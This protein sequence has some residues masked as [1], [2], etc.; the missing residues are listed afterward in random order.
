MGRI[1]CDRCY[2]K[3]MEILR[4]VVIPLRGGYTSLFAEIQ[5]PNCG[6]IRIFRKFIR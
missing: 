5:C 2:Q 6:N 3:E 4:G 1:Q